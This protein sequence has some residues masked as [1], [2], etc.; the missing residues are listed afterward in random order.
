MSR[1][2]D[3]P[4]IPLS[5]IFPVQP[6]N[7]DS[8]VPFARLVEKTAAQR[9]WFGQCF[10]LEAH[11]LA[12][13]LAG[14]GLR[15]PFGTAVTLMHLRHP[16]EA[17]L[18]ARTVSALS[19]YTFVAGV[20]TATPEMV[21]SLRGEAYRSPRYAAIRYVRQMRAAMAADG[22]DAAAAS[23]VSP[24]E[25]GLG[26]LR[27]RMA[28][29][30]ATVADVAITLMTPPRYLCEV[31]MPALAAGA[32]ERPSPPR[33]AAVV[34]VAVRRDGRDPLRVA[35]HAVGGKLFAPH[36]RDMLR[37][38][39][40]PLDSAGPDRAPAMLIDHGVVVTGT[41]VEIAAELREYVRAGASEIVLNAGG[42][43]ASEGLR[44]AA[45]DLL[46]ILA[47]AGAV[48]RRRT[49]ATANGPIGPGN[50]S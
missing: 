16:R 39:G 35:A 11:Q 47:A 49:E 43:A 3:Q 15:I 46:E 30:A 23:A 2:P 44:A 10:A 13:A 34:P 18:L 50:E 32:R 48:P 7:L 36:Y 25:I 29:A 4:A 40:V 9:L 20:G 8:T 21:E 42:V 38:A 45:V 28:R 12:S 31:L 1:S 22:I 41:A 5:V 19:G 27:P 26:V 24:V 37:R 6:G 17:A 14:R 33:V